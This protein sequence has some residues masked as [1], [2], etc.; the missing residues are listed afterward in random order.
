MNRVAVRLQEECDRQ[1][2]SI[3]SQWEEERRIGKKVRSLLSLLTACADLYAQLMDVR[4][5]RFPFLVSLTAAAGSTPRSFN[6]P[7]NAGFRQPAKLPSELPS[8]DDLIDA[9]EVDALLSELAQIS[10]RWELYRRFL[11][12]RLQVRCTVCSTLQDHRTR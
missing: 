4:T 7:F 11:Y 9:K 2:Q 10:G 8:D 1:G 6:A 5:Y 3:L 12:A